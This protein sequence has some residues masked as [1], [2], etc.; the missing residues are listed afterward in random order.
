MIKRRARPGAYNDWLALRQV[1]DLIYVEPEQFESVK[2]R[3]QRYA[4][5]NELPWRIVGQ[6]AG[7]DGMCKIG[8][9]AKD[10]K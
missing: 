3:L 9:E 10:A 2:G 1:G 7:V 6:L 8:I 5:N 4:T